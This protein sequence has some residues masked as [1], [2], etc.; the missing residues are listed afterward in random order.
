MGMLLHYIHRSYP[1]SRRKD[2]IGLVYQKL[3]QELGDHFGIQRPLDFTLRTTFPPTVHE[4]W[5]QLT[6]IS[7]IF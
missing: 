4:I 5:L 2:Y 7:T 3:G 6:Q 1:H